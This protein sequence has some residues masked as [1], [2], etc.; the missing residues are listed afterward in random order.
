M[1]TAFVPHPRPPR[2]ESEGP[3]RILMRFQC[4]H[5]RTLNADP[6]RRPSEESDSALFA[7]A[8]GGSDHSGPSLPIPRASVRDICACS[9]TNATAA[10]ADPGTHV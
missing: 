4:V 9:V 7:A 8:P 5:H 1:K 3:K 10:A 2:G 6:P